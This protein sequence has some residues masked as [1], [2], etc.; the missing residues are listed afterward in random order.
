MACQAFA[1]EV[2][3]PAT[4]RE[5]R[6]GVAPDKGKGVPV[7]VTMPN[8]TVNR[9]KAMNAG[10]QALK[11]AGV[12]GIMMDVWWG[13]VERDAPAPTTDWW[14]YRLK[15][16]MLGT[17]APDD[18]EDDDDDGGSDP[19]ND[20]GRFA[21]TETLKDLSAVQHLGLFFGFF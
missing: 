21:I 15:S 7:Y 18:N 12:E 11:S 17:T 8:N 5:Y 13:L 10:L 14:I 19:N 16:D 20:C 9:R 1:T 4:E 6:E 3:A 2:E